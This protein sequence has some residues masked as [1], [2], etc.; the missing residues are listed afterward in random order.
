MYDKGR[1]TAFV[2]MTKEEMA[3]R[4]WDAI[5]ILIVSGDACVD[6]P[7]FGPPLIARVLLDAGYRVAIIAQPDWRN[8]ESVKT[9]GRPLIG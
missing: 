2:P 6:H 3:A 9:F 4:G 7:T 5:D 1:L 8:A